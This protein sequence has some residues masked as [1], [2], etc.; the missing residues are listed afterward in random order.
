MEIAGW[1]EVLGGNEIKTMHLLLYL[2]ICF[3]EGR[4]AG[5]VNEIKTMH[6]GLYLEIFFDGVE[7]RGG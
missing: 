7:V 2:E 4:G 3:D 1:V 5:W 6:L